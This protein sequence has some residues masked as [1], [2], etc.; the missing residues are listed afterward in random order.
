MTGTA[1]ARA[2]DAEAE[3]KQ[4]AP[5]RTSKTMVLTTTPL[6]SKLTSR[7]T[8]FLPASERQT[9]KIIVL[10][11]ASPACRLVPAP[12]DQSVGRRPRYCEWS[13]QDSSQSLCFHA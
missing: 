8:V 10:R 2:D 12:G 7:L 9:I 3:A 4:T 6:Y 5:Q 13:R 1:W 11:R